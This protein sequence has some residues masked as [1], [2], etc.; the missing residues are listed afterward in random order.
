MAWMNL[1]RRNIIII[2]ET[3]EWREAAL[4]KILKE[5]ERERSE[6]TISYDRTDSQLLIKSSLGTV[7]FVPCDERYLCGLRVDE[8]YFQSCLFRKSYRFKTRE[9][10]NA[11]LGAC[12]NIDY[13]FVIIN[14]DEN[15]E[16]DGKYFRSM[17]VGLVN[18]IR[19][20]EKDEPHLKEDYPYLFL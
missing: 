11:C 9:M 1:F 16:Q 6:Y 18:Y 20:C 17:G 3:K 10:V 2:Y 13:C 19:Q 12:L 14:M 15:A 7:R 4:Q 8:C 5:F